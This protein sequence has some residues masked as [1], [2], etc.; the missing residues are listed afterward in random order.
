MCV[1]VCVLFCQLACSLFVLIIIINAACEFLPIK[2]VR[3]E[4]IYSSS[5]DRRPVGS[6]DPSLHL[7]T[8]WHKSQGEFVAVLGGRAESST[9]GNLACL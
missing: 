3:G 5:P 2:S 8:E 9:D 1:Y 4:P 6:F 7:I